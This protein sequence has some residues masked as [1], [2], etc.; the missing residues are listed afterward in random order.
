MG[1]LKMIS[2][3]ILIGLVFILSLTNIHPINAF[4]FPMKENNSYIQD[5]AN[6]LSDKIKTKIDSLYKE[7][8]DDKNII[9]S[10]VTI[11]DAVGDK[12]EYT[13]E[14]KKWWEVGTEKNGMIIAIYPESKDSCEIIVDESLKKYI[15]KHDIE[16]YE[17]AIKI[18][19]DNGNV[20]KSLDNVLNDI[21]DKLKDY[22]KKDYFIQVFSNFID[23]FKFNFSTNKSA[24]FV[25]LD[26]LNKTLN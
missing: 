26:I 13:K 9:A 3:I 7:Y 23:A 8:K 16:E 14:L 15:S 18:G 22:S 11:S 10:I 12:T 1:K 17:N 19:I 4:D 5:K 25:K 6:I 21:N 24:I 2:K 20:E